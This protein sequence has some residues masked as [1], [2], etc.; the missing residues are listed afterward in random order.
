MSFEDFK[1]LYIVLCLFLGLIILSPTLALVVRLPSG[2]RFS[3]LWV[4]GSGGLA[5]DYPFTIVDG[6]M[7]NVSL[8]VGNHMGGSEYYLVYV[9]VRNQTEALPDAFNGTPSVLEPDFEY[10]FFLR[11]NAVWERKTLFSFKGISF[12]GNL[13]RVSSF[14][15]DGHVLDV[16][17][18]AVWDEE[19]RGFYLQL[20]FELWRYDSTTSAF[21][22]HNRF[23][24]LWLNFTMPI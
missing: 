13:C 19:N 14:V 22:Y 11:D 6:E 23:V 7:Y 24:G 4:L 20:F 17:K 10:R 12:E 15:V 1:L 8:G 9:K 2:E 21:Q 18:L 3:E 16:D 5:E